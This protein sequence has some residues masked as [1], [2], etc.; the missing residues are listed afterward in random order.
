MIWATVAVVLQAVLPFATL[1]RGADSGIA[2]PRQV[3][4]R[5]ADAWQALW[6]EH[7]S[8]PPPAVDFSQSIVVGVFLGSRPTAGYEVEIVR[9]RRTGAGLAVEYVERRPAPDALAAQVLTAP[10]H[11][12][13]LA[14]T[15]DPIE[16]IRAER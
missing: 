6:K 8:G 11:L 14:R 7:A 9:I 4:V 13:T 3:V 10:F 16:F 12:V 2:E 5:F 1:A 15:A